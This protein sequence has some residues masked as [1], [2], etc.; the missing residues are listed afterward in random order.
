[1]A[2]SACGPNRTCKSHYRMF[3]FGGKADITIS[4]MCACDPKR[5]FLATCPTQT[6]GERA[7]APHAALIA[8]GPSIPRDKARVRVAKPAITGEHVRGAL[9][10]GPI[11]AVPI[12]IAHPHVDDRAPRG[13]AVELGKCWLW[14]RPEQSKNS[15]NGEKGAHFD[16]P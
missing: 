6:L 1:M 5:T 4:E 10:Y 2:M 8:I 16:L 14:S 15:S 7:L 11:L 13:W 9:L 3:A 12:H